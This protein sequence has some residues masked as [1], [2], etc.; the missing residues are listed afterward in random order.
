MYRWAS[1]TSIAAAAFEESSSRGSDGDAPVGGGFGEDTGGIVGRRRR[2]G[3]ERDGGG[4]ARRGGVGWDG[5]VIFYVFW[6][7]CG[8]SAGLDV[9][10]T[11]FYGTRC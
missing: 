2:L 11:Y 1:K 10:P 7:W 4:V 8:P 3:D 9:V 6:G 5:D